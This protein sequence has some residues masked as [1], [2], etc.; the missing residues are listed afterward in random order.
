M[1]LLV[2]LF[3]GAAFAGITAAI[4]TVVLPDRSVAI[5]AWAAFAAGFIGSWVAWKRTGGDG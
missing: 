2:A 4:S 5:P 1:R 3:I